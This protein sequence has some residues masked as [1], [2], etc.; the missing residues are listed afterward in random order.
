M[1]SV[2]IVH[3]DTST[4]SRTYTNTALEMC[5]GNEIELLDDEQLVLLQD[6]VDTSAVALFYQLNFDAITRHQTLPTGTTPEY[7][8]FSPDAANGYY[9]STLNGVNPLS[10]WRDSMTKFTSDLTIAGGPTFRWEAYESGDEVGISVSDI[11]RPDIDCGDYVRLTGYLRR[12]HEV[13]DGVRAQI[14]DNPSRAGDVAV[15]YGI[16]KQYQTTRALWNFLVRNMALTLNLSQQRDH[17]Y[18]QLRVHHNFGPTPL[19]LNSGF[20]VRVTKTFG[21][22]AGMTLAMD[23]IIKVTRS[24]EG[25]PVTLATP[26]AMTA[27]EISEVPVSWTISTEGVQLSPDETLS[28]I[29]DFTVGGTVSKGLCLLFD[30]SWELPDG[31]EGT[32][33]ITRKRLLYFSEEVTVVIDPEA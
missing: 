31:G 28:L 26:D 29:I 12:I 21:T 2:T 30:V 6:T 33:E 9:V 22:S 11:G 13:L 23:N 4:E 8:D 3:R 5:G 16:H 32:I 19:T 15:N 10:K 14:L 7:F 24:A 25:A 20:V 17:V 1:P 18:M 27:K